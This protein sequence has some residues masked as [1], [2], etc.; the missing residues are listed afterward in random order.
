ME[1]GLLLSASTGLQAVDDH[2]APEYK[3]EKKTP[4]AVIVYMKDDKLAYDESDKTFLPK[5]KKDDKIRNH[6]DYLERL[7]FF[8]FSILACLIIAAFMLGLYNCIRMNRFRPTRD[9]EDQK[10]KVV[11]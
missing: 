6:T 5:V 4:N 9:M 2:V 7:Y 10:L 1:D 3:L 11:Y 8:G